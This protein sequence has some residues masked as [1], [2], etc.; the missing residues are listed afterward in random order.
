MSAVV[1]PALLGVYGV[2]LSTVQVGA[3]VSHQGAIKHV[4]RHWT[5]QVLAAPYARKLARATARP[6][7]LMAVGLAGV[8]LLLRLLSGV[9]A[10]AGLFLWMVAVNLLIVVAQVALAALQAED[11]FWASFTT[12][13]IASATRSFLPPLLVTLM[14][15]SLFLLNT[16]FLLHTAVVAGVALWFLRSAWQRPAQAG[17]TAAD[18]LP[19]MVR[20]FAGVG[21]CSWLAAAAPRWFAAMA[22]A[23]EATGYFVLAGNLTLIVPATAGT[24]ALTYSFPALFRAARAGADRRVLLRMT[25]R[26]LAVVML[27]TQLG[28]VAVRMAAPW[29]VGP[30]IDAR[31]TEATGWLLATG[32]ATLAATTTQFYH[33]LLLAQNRESDCLR[34]SLLSATF[35]LVA[36]GVGAA[37]GGRMF[38]FVLIALPW[39]TVALEWWYTRRC[40]EADSSA[41]GSRLTG[42]G[43]LAPGMGAASQ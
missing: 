38:C 27:A 5:P 1:P 2:L 26:T 20:A 19:R 33:N 23:P 36:M 4:Q 16:G 12:S 28:L 15:A 24:I 30:V 7:L 10:N 43:E 18:E 31:Y 11:R 9:P 14:G 21:A 6:T 22:L 29:L 40:L 3:V 17:G 35:R 32:G 41:P 42:G 37:S 34:L 25:N 13:A 39:P 8:L